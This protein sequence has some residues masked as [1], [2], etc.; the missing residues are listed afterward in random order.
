MTEKQGLYYKYCY[1]A[2][3]IAAAAEKLYVSRSVVSRMLSDLEEEFDTVFF[4]RG[5]RGIVPTEAGKIMYK[6][7]CN[8]IKVQN[9]LTKERKVC[10]NLEALK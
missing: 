7:I 2:G 6:Y 3:N 1:E 5:K 10:T 8:A 4:T 9:E